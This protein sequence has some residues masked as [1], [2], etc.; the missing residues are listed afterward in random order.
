MGIAQV[1][2]KNQFEM[3]LFVTL[4]KP[5]GFVMAHANICTMSACLMIKMEL[6]VKYVLKA[7]DGGYSMHIFIGICCVLLSIVCCSNGQRIQCIVGLIVYGLVSASAYI[8]A[9]Y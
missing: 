4:R 8:Y 6:M 1:D 3:T 9:L 7:H 5:I 2:E